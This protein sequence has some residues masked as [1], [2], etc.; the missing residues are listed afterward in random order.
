MVFQ[1]PMCMWCV[2]KRDGMTCAAFPEGIPE[3]IITSR[4]IHTVP[5][6][7]DNGIQYEQASEPSEFVKERLKGPVRLENL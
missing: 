1:A 3:E 7:G 2:H 5:Y 6:P 4:V